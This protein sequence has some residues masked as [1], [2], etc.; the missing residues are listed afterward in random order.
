M[1][2]EDELK[3]PEFQKLSAVMKQMMRWYFELE[4]KIDAEIRDIGDI[5]VSFEKR[6]KKM[7]SNSEG[8]N[9][10]L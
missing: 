7:E 5:L 1:D 2:I 9:Y 10:D 3:T 8:E 6:L 4:K